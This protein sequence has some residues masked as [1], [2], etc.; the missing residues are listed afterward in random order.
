MM[1]YIIQFFKKI[2]VFLGQIY[3]INQMI[4]LFIWINLTSM[5]SDYP[6]VPGLIDMLK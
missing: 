6:W 5:R 4:Y 3:F 1:I 2:G